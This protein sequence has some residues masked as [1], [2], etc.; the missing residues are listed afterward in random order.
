M[1]EP[2]VFYEGGAVRAVVR[3]LA[4]HPVTKER[5]PVVDLP[6]MTIRFRDPS[7]A[8]LIER[9]LALG[10]VVNEGDGYYSGTAVPQAEG[11]HMVEFETGGAL[12]GRDKVGFTVE[13]F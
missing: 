13:P 10:T 1:L 9:T 2:E 12:P 7:R 5:S 6:A 11:R 4:V 8:V 3:V